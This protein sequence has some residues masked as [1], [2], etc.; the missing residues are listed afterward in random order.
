[1][2]KGITISLAHSFIVVLARANKRTNERSSRNE[3]EG[4]P[5]MA[6][7]R[8]TSAFILY[9]SHSE[10]ISTYVY[11]SLSF[12][13]RLSS[14]GRRYLLPEPEV[15]AEAVR[16]L[17]GEWRR[18][19]RQISTQFRL[20]LAARSESSIYKSEG[21]LAPLS[22]SFG[23]CKAPAKSSIWTLFA[24]KEGPFIRRVMGE[25]E[26]RPT[27]LR[28]VF[29]KLTALSL[30]FSLSRPFRKVFALPKGAQKEAR[31]ALSKLSFLLLTHTHTQKQQQK[32]GPTPLL[33]DSIGGE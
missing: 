22:L 12:G 1:M 6:R 24:L 17:A 4:R 18:R 10:H 27:Q 23:P 7:S 32:E 29:R 21:H 25:K 15:A 19:R 20:L 13:Q 33:I 31:V 2:I 28:S 14:F 3:R 11:K 30:S 8:T 26:R 16:E 9:L 5:K